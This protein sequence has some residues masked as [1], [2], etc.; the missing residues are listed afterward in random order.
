[1]IRYIALRLGQAVVVALIVSVLAFL[2]MQLVPGDPAAAIAGFETTPEQ[3]EKIRQELWLDRSLPVQYGHWMDEIL[4][5]RLGMSVRHHEDVSTVI[6][7]RAPISV[8]L[9]G[10][11]IL[12]GGIIGV[13]IGL[14]SAIRRGSFV[15]AVVRVFANFG[16]AM[17]VFWLGIILIYVVGLQLG[18]LP[19][20]GWTSPL[21]DFWLGIRKSIMPIICLSVFPMAFLARQTRSSMLEVVHEDYIRTAWAK[22]LRERVVVMRHALKN[23]LIPVI[24]SLGLLVARMAGGAVLTETVFNIPGMGRLMVDSVMN[25]DYMIVQGCIV[26]IAIIVL[27]T[28]LAVDLSYGLFNPRIRY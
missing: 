19:I 4:H 11:G 6:L 28:N 27:F 7:R 26:V 10:S 21:E 17:P 13:M 1:M 5:G 14:L 3:I 2:F 23:A 9:A 24:T 22:G 16:L 12:L 25:M 15:D 8:F 18:W 20:C